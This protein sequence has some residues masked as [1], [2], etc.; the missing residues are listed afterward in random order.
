[1]RAPGRNE[2]T[3][4]RA[5]LDLNTAHQSV[6]QRGPIAGLSLV[7]IRQRDRGRRL[8]RTMS[9]WR[10]KS[11]IQCLLHLARPSFSRGCSAGLFHRTAVVRTRMPGGVGGAAS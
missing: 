7:D 8:A 3:N 1:M 5:R 4:D 2:A 11:F 10:W 6:C 9:A